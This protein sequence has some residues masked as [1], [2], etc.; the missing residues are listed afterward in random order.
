MG[1]LGIEDVCCAGN[2]LAG[3]DRRAANRGVVKRHPHK[4]V[5]AER[6]EDAVQEAVNENAQTTRGCDE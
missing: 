6:Y 1:K 3:D 2:T 4:V 5:H